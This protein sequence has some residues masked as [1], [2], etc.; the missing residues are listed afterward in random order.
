MEVSEPCESGR[1]LS[2]TST[3]DGDAVWVV[4]GGEV[5]LATREDLRLSLARLEFGDARLVFLDVGQLTFCDG[6]G[7]RILTSFQQETAAA[8]Y[9][10]R[11]VHASPL[12]RKVMHLMG[13]ASK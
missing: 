3:A 8:G 6:V 2:V 10:V 12:M 9:D 13:E 5:D 7:C 1:W 11:F 4:I